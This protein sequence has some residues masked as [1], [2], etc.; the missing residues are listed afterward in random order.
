MPGTNSPERSQPLGHHSWGRWA[1]PPGPLLLFSGYVAHALP[2]GVPVPL[3]PDMFQSHLLFRGL[4][5]VAPR[6][7]YSVLFKKEP[8]VSMLLEGQTAV[9]SRARCK[10]EKV[11]E[12][13]GKVKI[14]CTEKVGNFQQIELVILDKVS[15]YF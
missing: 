10:V 5:I 15:W 13:L 3:L 2:G 6:S 8:E 1:P 4:P 14:L 9:R 11:G 12:T 7:G